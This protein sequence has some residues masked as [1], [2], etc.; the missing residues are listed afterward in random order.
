MSLLSQAEPQ[1]DE[2]EVLKNHSQAIESIPWKTVNQGKCN[3]MHF[4]CIPIPN[5]LKHQAP[6]G[7]WRPRAMC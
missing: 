1:P 6:G 3:T 5:P 2:R 7:F 4:R